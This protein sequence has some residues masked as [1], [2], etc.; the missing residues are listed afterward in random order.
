MD[1]KDKIKELIDHLIKFVYISHRSEIRTEP[2]WNCCSEIQSAF[3]DL[4]NEEIN[5]DELDDQVF[6][7]SIEAALNEINEIEEQE[8]REGIC[9]CRN[10]T[11]FVREIKN[12]VMR[13]CD[14]P[15]TDR[16][17]DDIETGFRLRWNYSTGQKVANDVFIH[18]VE[19]YLVAIESPI[20]R[21]RMNMV[22]DLILEYMEK[23]EEW[24]DS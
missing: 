8:E 4:K 15:I 11:V 14:Q 3:R 23:M 9:N 17:F 16:E 1:I 5:I 18:A 13:H 24:G 10:H 6:N 7:R 20:D 21:Q 22:V 12:Y 2:D 19:Q